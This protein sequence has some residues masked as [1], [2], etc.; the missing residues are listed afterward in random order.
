MTDPLNEAVIELGSALGTLNAWNSSADVEALQ[1]L[2]CIH[3]MAD[4]KGYAQLV[5]IRKEIGI[6][7]D[8]MTRCIRM[9][10]GQKKSASILSLGDSTD[11]QPL[12][13]VASYDDS[14]S[15]KRIALTPKGLSIVQQILL[16]LIHRQR[17]IDELEAALR[18]KEKLVS[19]V[20]T[21]G[22]DPGKLANAPDALEPLKMRAKAFLAAL[23]NDVARL[24]AKEIY[25]LGL[26]AVQRQLLEIPGFSPD[27]QSGNSEQVRQALGF[28]SFVIRDLRQDD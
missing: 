2:L 14:P 27:C 24:S 13:D 16:P 17:R 3:I 25:D 4:D 28:N 21:I 20:R 9:L 12:V 6:A 19:A 22:F 7:P 23:V 8:R 10:L 11:R 15:V 5:E 26:P 1:V 18:E